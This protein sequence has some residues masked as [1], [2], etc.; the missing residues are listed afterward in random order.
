[1]LKMGET[2][3]AGIPRITGINWIMIQLYTRF[4][5]NRFGFLIAPVATCRK[6]RFQDVMWRNRC[7][8]IALLFIGTGLVVN[9]REIGVDTFA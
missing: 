5:I 9:C 4:I 1:M 3:I 7:G 6:N 8:N 2:L